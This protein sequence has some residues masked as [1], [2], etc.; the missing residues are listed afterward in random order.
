MLKR[1]LDERAGAGRARDQGDNHQG[2]HAAR[3][4]AFR[5]VAGLPEPSKGW[6][7]LCIA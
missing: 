6:V 3:A 4:N 5:R 2:P 7:S 1:D